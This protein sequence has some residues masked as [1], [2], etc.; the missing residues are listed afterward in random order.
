MITD[1]ETHAEA[2]RKVRELVEARNQ[3][4]GM[5][6][7]VRKSLEEMGDKVEVSERDAIEAAATELEEALKGDDVEAINEKTTTLA[8]ASHKL[9][10][11]MYSENGGAEDAADA[12]DDGVVDAEFEEVD[13][14]DAD[15]SKDAED[16]KKDD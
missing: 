2:D 10:E 1:A 3:G 9:A 5:L 8:T 16:S 11:Q 15:D 14:S 7:G 4:E 6:N 12:S 13:G